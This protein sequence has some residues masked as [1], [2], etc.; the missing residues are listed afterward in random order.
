MLHFNLKLT[1]N[2]HFKEIEILIMLLSMKEK[3]HYLSNNENHVLNLTYMCY[4]TFSFFWMSHWEKKM[5]YQCSP[6]QA[7][8]G[9]IYR[10]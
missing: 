1:I 2:M 10:L 8:T 6:Y 7:V 4:I 9:K 3:N 5:H